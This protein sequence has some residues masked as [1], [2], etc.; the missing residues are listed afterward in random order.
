MDNEKTG[1]IRRKLLI[2]VVDY[3]KEKQ[4]TDMYLANHIPLSL[5]TH[6]HGTANSDILDYLG[7]GETKKNI[8]FSIVAENKLQ[9]IFSQL[10]QNMH[11]NHHGNGVAFTLPLSCI[12]NVLTCLDG[13]YIEESNVRKECEEN[14]MKSDRLY[15]LIIVIVTQG[16]KEQ[17][18][19]AA[20]AAGAKG[21]TVVHTKG[22]GSPEAAKFLEITVQPEKE[23]ILILAKREIKSAIMES[24]NKA[25]GMNTKAKGIMFSVPVDEAIGLDVE[26]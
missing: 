15:E 8:T 3:I 17:T 24:M 1:L 12:S 7:L 22:I 10:V 18:M 23:L 16:Y 11:L 9:T 14:I 19:E 25:V 4:L 13:S 21:G 6:G 2:T 26:F 5:V 20:K